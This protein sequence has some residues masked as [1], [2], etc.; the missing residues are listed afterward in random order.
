[1]SALLTA[2]DL[3]RSFRSTPALRGA[4]LTVEAGEIVAVMGPSGS[5]KSTLLHCAAGILTVDRGS[6]Q[7]RGRDIS[8]LSD[9]DRSALRRT[10]FGF[11]FQFGR[12]VPELTCRENV[13]L[14]LRLAGMRRRAADVAADAWLERLGC[15]PR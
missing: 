10:D 2:V 14:L 11:V 6:V 13:T 8:A 15:W 7:Y 3:H 5:G 9:R 1:M 4:D 12:L